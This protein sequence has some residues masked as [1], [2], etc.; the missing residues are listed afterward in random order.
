MKT[1]TTSAL[2]RYYAER[3]SSALQLF[4]GR[5]VLQGKHSITIKTL[6]CFLSTLA[7]ITA[8]ASLDSHRLD[9]DVLFSSS[10]V[11]AL[12]AF[13]LTEGRGPARLARAERLARLAYSERPA[14]SA[15]SAQLARFPGLV[16]GF[17]PPQPHPLKQA[18]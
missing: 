6:L 9:I 10:G 14:R 1:R 11:A 17:E 15:P 3:F 12:F 2:S 13:A 18:A 7:L 4:R 5:G 16:A 8:F